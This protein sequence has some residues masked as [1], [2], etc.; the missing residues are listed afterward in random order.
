MASNG[1]I[2]PP[3]CGHN[4]VGGLYVASSVLVP[5][6]LLEAVRGTRTSRLEPTLAKWD[7]ATALCG[8]EAEA[9][10]AATTEAA[11]TAPS[12]T[13]TFRRTLNPVL[14]NCVSGFPRI[15]VIVDMS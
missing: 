1:F 3:Q 6:R 8:T 2:G 15:T 13:A 11:N 4:G 12:P 5:W 10:G 14:L 9:S 7:A